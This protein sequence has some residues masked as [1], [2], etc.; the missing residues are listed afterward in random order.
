MCQLLDP[1]LHFPGQPY[2]G[3]CR[4]WLGVVFYRGMGG[5]SEALAAAV[6]PS[7]GARP[8]AGEVLSREGARR[9][10]SG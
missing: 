6:A 7:L 4:H 8:W 5:L 10:V 2:T 9:W 3:L 1:S